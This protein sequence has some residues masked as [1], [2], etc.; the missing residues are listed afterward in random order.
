MGDMQKVSGAFIFV[1]CLEETL[2]VFSKMLL[3]K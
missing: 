1:L 2:C 3:T